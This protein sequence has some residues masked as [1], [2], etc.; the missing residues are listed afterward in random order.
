MKRFILS[1]LVLTALALY[2]NTPPA[3][4]GTTPG[5]FQLAAGTLP[6]IKAS[7]ST[8][9]MFRLDTTTGKA[10]KL[11]AVPLR[12]ANGMTTVPTWIE[13]EEMNGELYQA[14]IQSLRNP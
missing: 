4:T 1:L 5:R 3:P 2:A 13:I 10:W 11:A 12:H 7:E 9:T 14:A 6:D 8:Q